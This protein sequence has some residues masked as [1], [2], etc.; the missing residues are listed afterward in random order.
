MLARLTRARMHQMGLSHLHRTCTE[1]ARAV[2]TKH[3]TFATFLS[4]P[5]DGLQRW[6]S[7]H[8]SGILLHQRRSVWL[9]SLRR[10]RGTDR[11]FL[12]LSRAAA[13]PPVFMIIVTLVMECLLINIWMCAPPARAQHRCMVGC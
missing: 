2:I 3:S 1:L 12:S 8:T 4:E 7:A 13:A 5:L 10:T 11:L 9:P 6:Q